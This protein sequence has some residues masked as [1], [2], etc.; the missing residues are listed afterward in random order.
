MVS[1]RF[2]ADLLQGGLE[3]PCK[4]IFTGIA[5]DIEKVTRLL[6]LTEGEKN[7]VRFQIVV[8]KSSSTSIKAVKSS[9]VSVTVAVTNSPT[10][11][12]EI[13]HHSNLS[14]KVA[15]S[16]TRASILISDSSHT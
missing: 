14:V 15:E 10:T 2:S 1:K 12:L 13:D 8:N 11:T 7:S 6:R 3:I 9:D 5:K 4:L 16:S